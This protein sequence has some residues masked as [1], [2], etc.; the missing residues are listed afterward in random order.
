VQA[1]IFLSKIKTE[2]QE[3]QLL[4]LLDT[5]P[6][7]VLICSQQSDGKDLCPIYAN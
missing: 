7:K 3:K 2:Q 6:D 5:V 4:N 1:K